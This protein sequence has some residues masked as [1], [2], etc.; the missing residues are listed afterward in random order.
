MR[1]E[2]GG[3][4]VDADAVGRRSRWELQKDLARDWAR[5]PRPLLHAADIGGLI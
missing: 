1:S 2:C 4:A 3:C 5:L